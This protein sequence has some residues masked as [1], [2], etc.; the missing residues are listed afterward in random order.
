MVITPP[1]IVGAA[2]PIR[3]RATAEVSRSAAVTHDRPEGIKGV[4]AMV[5]AVFLVQAG[6]PKEMVEA[7]IQDRFG[8]DFTRP[9]D[10]IRPSYR[11]DVS[12]QRSV[13]ESLIA[14]LGSAEYEVMVRN[15][16]SLGGR[17]T[18]RQPAIRAFIGIDLSREAAP[19]A[20]TLLNLDSS[21]DRSILR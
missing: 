11:F 14:F 21:V 3:T 8:Y 20:T 2:G 7:E 15:A 5:L 10:T 1:C 12:C 16:I 19:D 4:R 9:L 13:P 6:R 18:L 17:C